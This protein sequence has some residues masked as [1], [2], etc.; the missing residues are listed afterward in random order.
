MSASFSSVRAVRHPGSFAG[1]KHGPPV[2]SGRLASGFLGSAGK[3]RFGALSISAPSSARRRGSSSVVVAVS[4]DVVKE[5][6][7][8]PSSSSSSGLV[9]R[10]ACDFADH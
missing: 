10:G 8:K 4:S 2:A 7:L 6:K 5:E 3:L 1:E 9:K